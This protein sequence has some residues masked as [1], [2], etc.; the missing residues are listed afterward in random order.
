[1]AYNG[2]HKRVA[3]RRKL[4]IL[5]ALTNSKSV[6]KNCIIMD[7]LQHIKELKLKLEAIN[8]EYSTL[9]KHTKVPEVRIDKIDQGLVNIRVTCEKG[10]DNLLVCILEALEKMGLNVLQARVSTHYFFAME[11]IAEFQEA[12]DERNVSRAVFDAIE[13][14]VRG[15][16]ETN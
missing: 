9:I 15:G 3:L 14:Q 8:R 5:K 13:K 2:K 10:Q 11:A 6:K 7:A 12:L 1:M 4:Q 16:Q